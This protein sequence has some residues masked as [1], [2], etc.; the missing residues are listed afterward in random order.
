MNTIFKKEKTAI[1]PFQKSQALI[2]Y[3]PFRISRHPNYLGMLTILI[4]ELFILGSLTYLIAPAVFFILMETL[5]I[6]QEEKMIAETFGKE[7]LDYKKKTRKW[8]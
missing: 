1:K 5:S 3:G 8:F 2:T 4:G 7:Y 6:P